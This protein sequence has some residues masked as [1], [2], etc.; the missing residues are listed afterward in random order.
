M[1]IDTQDGRFGDPLAIS[2]DGRTVAA[3]GSIDGSWQIRVFRADEVTLRWKQMGNPVLED[4]RIAGSIGK[5]VALPSNGQVLV[6]VGFSSLRVFTFDEDSFTWVQQSLDM[7]EDTF[8]TNFD[9]SVAVSSGGRVVAASNT[10]YDSE[11]LT[12]RGRV[13]VFGY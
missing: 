13:R 10:G 6:V 4:S 2:A 1:T 8:F 5:S 3:G 12:N 7:E 9:G 11:G